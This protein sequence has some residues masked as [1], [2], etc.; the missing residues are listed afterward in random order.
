MEPEEWFGDPVEVDLDNYEFIMGRWYERSD[1]CPACGGGGDAPEGWDCEE[2]DGTGL[3]FG[4]EGLD[5]DDP[6]WVIK[7]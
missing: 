7:A 1:I 5:S 2:C 6:N 4:A 3:K